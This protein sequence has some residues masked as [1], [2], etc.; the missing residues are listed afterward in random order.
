MWI[1]EDVNRR[2]YIATREPIFQ[3]VPVMNMKTGEIDIHILQGM[4]I[5]I[6]KWEWIQTKDGLTWGKHNGYVYDITDLNGANGKTENSSLNQEG[7][8]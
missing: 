2:C 3:H 8:L 1:Y 4:E 6:P 5:S 7:P